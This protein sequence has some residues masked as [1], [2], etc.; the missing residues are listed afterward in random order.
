[1]HHAGCKVI[2]TSRSRREKKTSSALWASGG[3]GACRLQ[4]TVFDVIE[5]H[6][7]N[8]RARNAWNSAQELGAF[9]SFVGGQRRESIVSGLISR[10]MINFPAGDQRYGWRW[11]FWVHCQSPIRWIFPH[12]RLNTLWKSQRSKLSYRKKVYLRHLIKPSELINRT[13][14]CQ[15]RKI[16][17]WRWATVKSVKSDNEIYWLWKKSKFQNSIKNDTCVRYLRISKTPRAYSIYHIR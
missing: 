11:L 3:H 7:Q 2:N 1:M 15:T 12:L 8:L 17:S 10:R 4:S 5:S 16:I 13:W 14:D 6:R 9:P